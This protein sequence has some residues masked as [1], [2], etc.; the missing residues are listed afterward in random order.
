MH[1]STMSFKFQHFKYASVG[2]LGAAVF[3]LALWLLVECFNVSVL[4]ATSAAF[5][6]VTLQN[7]ILHYVWTFTSNHAHS[8]ALPR[9]ALMNVAGFCLNWS[10][11]YVGVKLLAGNYLLVQTV[12]VAGVIAWNFVLSTWW[13]FRDGKEL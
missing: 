7:Y 1:L 13:I 9:F 4:V 8:V 5:I 2:L 10:V 6:L 3:Y 12:A 11:M